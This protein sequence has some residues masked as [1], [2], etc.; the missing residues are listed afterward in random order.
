MDAM[1]KK[2]ADLEAEIAKRA[3]RGELSKKISELTKK[4]GE[5]GQEGDHLLARRIGI[6]SALRTR[7]RVGEAD[8]GP[9][10]LRVSECSRVV[11]LNIG[12]KS[13]ASLPRHKLF[14]TPQDLHGFRSA[15][16]VFIS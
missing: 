14:Y 10:D 1:T 9:D 5:A 4:L 15:P 8:S 11:P 6:R 2:I 16:S 12:K 13:H 7:L 3:K